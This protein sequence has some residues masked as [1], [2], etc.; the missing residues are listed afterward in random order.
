MKLRRA[1]LIAALAASSALVAACN[2]TLRNHGYR[3]SDGEIPE[4]TPGEGHTGDGPVHIGQPVHSRHV[5]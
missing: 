4:F 5:R 3:Y 2:P 1:A